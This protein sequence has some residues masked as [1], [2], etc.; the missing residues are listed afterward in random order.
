VSA[1]LDLAA[2][3][4]VPRDLAHGLLASPRGA[5]EAAAR[6]R[7]ARARGDVTTYSPKVFLPLTNLCRN[8]CGYCSFRRNPDE[9][10]AWTMSPDEVRTFLEA[11]RATGCT[12]ALFCLGDTPESFS[13]AYRELLRSFGHG[14]TVDYLVA[15]GSLALDL[16]LL[17]HT[18][19]GVLSRAD[20]V[21]LR[22]V[23]ASQ[24]LMLESTA[25]HLGLPGGAHY[26]APDKAPAVRLAVHESAGVER[27][28]F[29][30][31]LLVGIGEQEAER[32]DTLLAIAD[33]HATY[34]HIQEVIVQRFTSRPGVR[35]AAWPEP[36]QEAVCRAVAAGIDDFGGISPLTPD[37]IN[38]RHAWPHVDALGALCAEG[39][40][41]LR[42]R[43]PVHARFLDEPGW[44]ADRVRAVAAS[45]AGAPA[46]EVG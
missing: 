43:L 5:L 3:G 40:S 26:G 9:P 45:C 19:A 13:T 2:A 20:L 29:T 18:N 31:G 37:F 35:M 24:G 27:I 46:L 25:D 38:P 10:G 28:P 34:G 4:P 41:T 11:G 6:A 36:D 30:S 44:V 23:N 12:E 42:P 21:R 8:A 32:V 1:L 33:L 39:G 17:P 15:S 7:R 22:A 14:S 16:G